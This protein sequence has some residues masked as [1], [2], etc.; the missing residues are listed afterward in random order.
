MPSRLLGFL[1]GAVV[2][3]LGTNWFYTQSGPK[4][5]Q[6]INDAKHKAEEYGQ[7]TKHKA[8]ELAQNVKHKAEDFGK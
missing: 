7:D 6:A 5:Q 8:E 1:A 3:A 4:T 2:G